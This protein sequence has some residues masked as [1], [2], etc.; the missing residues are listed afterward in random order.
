MAAERVKFEQAALG[1]AVG[2]V[3]GSPWWPAVEMM[4]RTRPETPRSIIDW[5]TY[6]VKQEGAG[7]DDVGLPATPPA[8]CRAALLV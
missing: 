8:T 5:A 2:D 4:L 7:Q 3:A 1:G 6:L